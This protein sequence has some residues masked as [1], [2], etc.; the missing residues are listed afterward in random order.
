MGDPT[1]E[2]LAS[3]IEA[4]ESLVAER[5]DIFVR[6]SGIY[7]SVKGLSSPKL[8]EIYVSPLGTLYNTFVEL[9]SK[10]SKINR[11]LPARNRSE[12]K[13][14]QKATEEL[15]ASIISIQEKLSST[16]VSPADSLSHLAL[17]RI[18][19]PIFSGD[20]DSWKSFKTAYE[21]T[22]HKN[23][24]LSDFTKLQYLL[25]LLSPEP[26][27]VINELDFTADNYEAIY[28]KLCRH[29]EDRRRCFNQAFRKILNQNCSDLK[30]FLSVQMAAAATLK[31]ST[32]PNSLDYMLFSLLLNN[33]P[34]ETRRLFESQRK[35]ETV[36]T[37]DELK[38]FICERIR[39][40]ELDLTE[41]ST[42]PKPKNV[43][44]PK[45]VPS[46]KEGSHVF[47]ISQA[48]PPRNSTTAKPPTI[49]SQ[50]HSQTVPMRSCLCHAQKPRL[51]AHQ[52]TNVDS[53]NIKCPLCQRAHRIYSCPA[54]TQMS[55][56]QRQTW[57]WE[58][59][60]CSNCLG[61][62]EDSECQSQR[63]CNMCNSWHHS[64]LHLAPQSRQTPRRFSRQASRP[65]STSPRNQST[66]VQQAKPRRSVSPPMNRDKNSN[67]SPSPDLLTKEPQASSSRE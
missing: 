59:N 58:N 67:S 63:R 50:E 56:H 16:A 7:N 20:I 12:V 23:L 44:K 29:Y 8:V 61:R 28:L 60:R 27:S 9:Q 49:E 15:L 30:S 1:P 52:W 31:A 46:P 33:L 11:L 5:D 54:Y 4:G 18:D 64:S 39:L 48:S 25:S 53:S 34:S 6:L 10:L 57:V 42:Q 47:Q 37:V 40:S 17:P 2:E 66:R 43:S 65:R 41:S 35:P 26:K 3:L 51:E 13:N 45:V 24:K 22:V 21:S 32:I 55:P 62:H 19:L 14:V 38:Q 36:P